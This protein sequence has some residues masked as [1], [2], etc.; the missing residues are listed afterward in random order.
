MLAQT[1]RKLEQVKGLDR[2]VNTMNDAVNKVL[3]PGEVKDA[4]HGKQLGHAL[5]PMLIAVPIGFNVAATVL[6][7]MGGER[8]RAAARRLVGV[9]L[10]A[11]PPT[12][13]AG[14]ADF[15]SLG[16][17]MRP[18]RVAVVHAGSNAVA[19]VLFTASWL[20]RRQ[21]R[22]GA[23]KMFSLLGLTGL[24]VGGYLGGH[25]A[26]SQGVGV[27]R[28]ADRAPRPKDWTDAA[29][30]S[31]LA[32]GPVRV[33]VSGQPVMLVRKDAEVYALGAVCSHLGGP[34]E[35]GQVVGG[36]DECVVCPWH[37][38]MFRL[39]D[40]SVARGPATAAQIPYDV[41]VSGDRIEVRAR[42]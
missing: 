23:G 17:N 10:V 22:H 33:E 2:V 29:A 8:D 14:L 31:D 4:L 39:S 40:G 12:V 36:D 18:K 34:L 16:K 15:S 13:A 42:Q 7:L 27:N 24:S 6:D 3:P 37:G 26:Y 38:S 41:R 28:N 21:G 30:V 35:E 19:S 32:A 11:T 9:A 20:A 25:L 5:H 1:I